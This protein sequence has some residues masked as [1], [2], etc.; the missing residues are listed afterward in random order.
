MLTFKWSFQCQLTPSIV[1]SID[2]ILQGGAPEVA[3]FACTRIPRHPSSSAGEPIT[4]YGHLE[5]LMQCT[6]TR[7]RQ[8]IP[9]VKWSPV[10]ER[11]TMQ[12][13]DRIFADDINYDVYINP[14]LSNAVDV[15]LEDSSN[16]DFY[17][18][19]EK[20]NHSSQDLRMD[21][22]LEDSID[23]AT[24]GMSD[25]D[26]KPPQALSSTPNITRTASFY[27]QD[28]A[29]TWR[30]SF[31]K[32]YA[33]FVT[34]NVSVTETEEELQKY[35]PKSF[36]YAS[37]HLEFRR[38]HL[39]LTMFRGDFDQ[40]LGQYISFLLYQHPSSAWH[41]KMPIDEILLQYFAT[42]P[43]DYEIA[44]N[45]SL[46]NL[47]LESTQKDYANYVLHKVVF[48]SNGGAIQ[49]FSRIWR[50]MMGLDYEPGDRALKDFKNTLSSVDSLGTNSSIWDSPLNQQQANNVH[51][52]S[53][54]TW[55]IDS[56]AWSRIAQ[57]KPWAVI[58]PTTIC[59]AELAEILAGNLLSI[60]S[61]GKRQVIMHTPPS[62]QKSLSR[63]R[64]SHINL[65]CVHFLT[66]SLHLLCHLNHIVSCTKIDASPSKWM[67]SAIFNMVHFH[68]LLLPPHSVPT[69]QILKNV[70]DGTNMLMVL[71][72]LWRYSI[73]LPTLVSLVLG[74]RIATVDPIVLQ[75]TLNVQRCA[76]ALV[77]DTTRMLPFMP[78]QAMPKISIA[79]HHLR[80]LV[81][82]W[83]L[84]ITSLIPNLVS[85][86]LSP[87]GAKVFEEPN[88][89]TSPFHQ[90]QDYAP[91]A[92]ASSIAL[93][94][95]EAHLPL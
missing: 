43:S 55:T 50:A 25:D 17:S 33:R 35:V 48:A 32:L 90:D 38:Y 69:V 22:C 6:E 26:P 13:A 82:E 57:E 52:A 51:Y 77:Y 2:Q 78:G 40:L 11:F 10:S 74:A 89:T 84:S 30:Q 23:F 14:C 44:N 8:M 36:P 95:I 59:F 64:S 15:I 18:V 9:N 53:L 88:I 79:D 12:D 85:C 61:A 24:I 71:I 58:G 87:V 76:K 19:S 66:A 31:S 68:E 41:Q 70:Y 16:F 20:S 45:P 60:D 42:A 92:I 28:A 21:I 4:V 72:Q 83:L 29:D 27:R 67:L 37:S 56:R 47:L 91:V 94:Q 80:G 62:M 81:R 1:L 65:R 39:Q 93:S 46:G 5:T 86:I 63:I 7:C 49:P 75:Q 3:R 73:L 34:S 54:L